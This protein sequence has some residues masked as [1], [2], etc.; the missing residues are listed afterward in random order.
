L[1]YESSRRDVERITPRIQQLYDLGDKVIYLGQ[2]YYGAVA[3][4]AAV[5]VFLSIFYFDIV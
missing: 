5:Q 1:N 3:T 2:D 4:I